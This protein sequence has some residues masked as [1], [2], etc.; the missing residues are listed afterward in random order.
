MKKI[1]GFN[2]SPTKAGVLET[3]MTKVLKSTGYEFEL[4]SLAKKEIKYCLGCVG[5][6]KNNKCILRD[7]M[8]EL[9][10][11]FMEADAVVFGGITRH[12]GANA[13][14]QN[15]MERFFPLY[16]RKILSTGKPVAIVSG[17]LYSA[18][19]AYKD[20]SGF[21]NG[22]KMNEVGSLIVG[23]NASCYKCGF[24]EVCPQSAHIAINGRVPITKDTFYK[25]ENDSE[26]VKKAVE[27]GKKIADTLKN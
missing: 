18:Q 27:L 10:E 6:A 23:G 8:D 26:C 14:M 20:M 24:G 17:G 4:I 22:F 7:D 3:A 1:I 13:I 25:F 12:N 15:F 11:K 16:H 9:L 21:V 2:A 19:E 5:C